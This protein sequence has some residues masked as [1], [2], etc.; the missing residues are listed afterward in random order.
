MN[1]KHFV[2]VAAAT[3][4]IS[5]FAVN[6]TEI[7]SLTGESISASADGFSGTSSGY[8][9]YV[10]GQ[11]VY[12]QWVSAWGHDYYIG[13][14]G[15]AVQGVQRI[16]NDYYYFGEDNT[17]FKRSDQWVSQWGNQYYA[18]P[19]G[20]FYNDVKAIDGTYY[21]FDRNGYNMIRNN[22]VQ[23]S[24]GMWYMFG[25]DGRIVTGWSDWYG[26]RYYFD[27]TTYLKVTG[28]RWIDGQLYHF[29]SDGQLIGGGYNHPQASSNNTYPWGQCTYYVKQQLGYVGNWWGNADQWANS[30]R[31]AGYSVDHN[32]AVGTAVVFQGGQAGAAWGYGH[33]A[34][35]RQ[36]N[37]NSIYIEEMNAH[38]V[39]VVSS[40]W[41]NNASSYEY[42][43]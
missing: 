14:D 22:Y 16:G 4:G 1:F 28:D 9:Y 13:S 39:G 12:N 6:H 32:P 40:R 26:S 42:I 11:K 38:G 23:S 27:S 41:V 33:V 34:V 24:W 43:H 8:E 7:G 30:A 21:A 35:V 3:A 10:N 2:V 36:V 20:K 37:G 15:K 19:D 25:S 5:F 31:N 29:N 17:Y 18:G